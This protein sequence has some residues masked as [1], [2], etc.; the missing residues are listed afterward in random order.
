MI[1]MCLRPPDQSVGY[2]CPFDIHVSST[3]YLLSMLNDVCI[4]LKSLTFPFNNSI[5]LCVFTLILG[6]PPLTLITFF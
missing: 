6:L 2:P 4:I 3:G 1:K 5:N